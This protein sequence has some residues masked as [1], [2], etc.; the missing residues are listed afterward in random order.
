MHLTWT[1]KV[2]H[3]KKYF[4]VVYICDPFTMGINVAENMKESIKCKGLTLLTAI[5]TSTLSFHHDSQPVPTIY[6]FNIS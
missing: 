5:S 2:F 3:A 1:N 6:F 4:I